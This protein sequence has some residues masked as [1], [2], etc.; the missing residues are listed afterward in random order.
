M[1]LLYLH[2]VVVGKG[3]ENFDLDERGGGVKERATCYPSN[4]QHT[5]PDF[6]TNKNKEFRGVPPALA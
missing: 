3:R 6:F 1:M 4:E 5:Y 2:F